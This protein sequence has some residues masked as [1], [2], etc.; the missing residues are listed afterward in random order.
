VTEQMMPLHSAAYGLLPYDNK[1]V[2]YFQKIKSG[3]AT[4]PL[5]RDGDAEEFRED[6]QSGYTPTRSGRE[7]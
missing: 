5:S 1:E 6:Q 7:V 2:I 3:G 4:R